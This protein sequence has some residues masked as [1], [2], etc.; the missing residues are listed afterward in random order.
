M[1]ISEIKDY[2]N[3]AKSVEY[4]GDAIEKSGLWAS[5]K[6]MVEKYLK[7]DAKILDIG[8]GAGRTTFNLYKNGYKN[9]TGADIAKQLVAHANAYAANNGLPVEFIVA[10]VRELPFEAASFGGALFSYNGLMTIPKQE[11]REK[12]LA[13]IYRVL[14]PG[15][16]FIFTAHDR[17]SLVK[18][19]QFWQDEK[20]RW[21]SGTQ[22]P[23]LDDYGDLHMTD[24]SGEE[25]F[26]HV[27]SI[28]E[29][30]KDVTDAG[31]KVLEYAMRSSIAK[32]SASVE[33]FSDDTVFWVVQKP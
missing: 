18:F 13:E 1:E 33:E 14:K 28:A 16:I 9:I 6:I 10:D 5:E 32:E 22:H 7:K 12:A 25:S 31:F 4:Y 26:V 20:E 15:G 21:K 8:S 27:P 24:G 11:N 19:R 2:Y 17:D 29:V 3:S 23:K 30:E